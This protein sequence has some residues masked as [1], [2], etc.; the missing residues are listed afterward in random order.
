ME[1]IYIGNTNTVKVS[2]AD[3]DGAAVE[4]AAPVM[5]LTDTDGVTVDGQTFPASLIHDA[6]GVYVGELGA[7]LDLAHNGVY[8]L[9]IRADPF[10]GTVLKSPRCR[11]KNRT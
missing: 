2:L 4:D 7:A 8:K 11:A 10:G 6:D 3:L 1:V 9:V 5:T